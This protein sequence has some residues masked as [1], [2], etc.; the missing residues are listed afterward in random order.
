MKSAISRLSAFLSVRVLLSAVVLLMVPVSGRMIAHHNHVAMANYEALLTIHGVVIKH[1]LI[2]PHS[3]I[4]VEARDDKGNV[5]EW[6]GY[7]GTPGMERRLGYSTK[8]FKV[9]EER[10]SMSGFPNKNGQKIMIY[11]RMQRENGEEIPIYQTLKND[12]A[13]FLARYGFASAD[14]LPPNLHRHIGSLKH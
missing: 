7:G 12:L 6:V 13:G 3:V 2:N 4:T 5:Q 14:D 10:I 1:E 11:V 8:M 9:G